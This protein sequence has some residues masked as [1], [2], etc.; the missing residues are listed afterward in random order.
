ML[1]ERQ[2]AM[3]PAAM[4]RMTLEIHSWGYPPPRAKPRG[5]VARYLFRADVERVWFYLADFQLNGEARIL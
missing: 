1:V 3:A 2:I 4:E 5:G